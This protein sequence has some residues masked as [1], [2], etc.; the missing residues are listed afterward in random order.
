MVQKILYLPA[1]ASA[2]G[3]ALDR[4]TLWVHLLMLFLFVGW[5][6]YF[7]VVL[8]RFRASK[9]LKANPEGVQNH[10]STYVEVGVLHAICIWCVGSAIC[11]TIL[12]ALSVTSATVR[13]VPMRAGRG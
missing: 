13:T 5:S 1:L 7:V 10:A 4:M 8:L 12:A 9:N 11:M 3:G 6:I 2:H